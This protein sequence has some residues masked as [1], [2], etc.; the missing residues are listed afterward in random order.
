MSAAGLAAPAC[1]GFPSHSRLFELGERRFTASAL[2]GLA[3]LRWSVAVGIR[4]PSGL[5]WC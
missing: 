5:R 4:S 1:G 2:A 3:E